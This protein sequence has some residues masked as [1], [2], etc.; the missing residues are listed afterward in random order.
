MSLPFMLFAFMEMFR[1]MFF[2]LNFKYLRIWMH[3]RILQ[4]EL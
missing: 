1:F 4:M 3:T 2:N